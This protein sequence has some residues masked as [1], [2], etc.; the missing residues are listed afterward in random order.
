[1]RG[2]EEEA[3][4]VTLTGKC[5]PK[6]AKQKINNN[7]KNEQI[8]E[9]V[10]CERRERKYDKI[11]E[12][13]ETPCG[14][15]GCSLCVA[16]CLSVFLVLWHVMGSSHTLTDIHTHTGTYHVPATQSAFCVCCFCL[17]LALA[18]LP[19]FRVAWIPCFS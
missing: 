17:A 4:S 16:R 2:E 5:A 8:M 3:K 13:N 10:E 11:Y 15:A 19:C 6:K 7:S 9:K 1:M 18:L 14:C 12:R